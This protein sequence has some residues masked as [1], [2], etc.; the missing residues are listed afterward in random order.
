MEG[1]DLAALGGDEIKLVDRVWGSGDAG[2]YQA[3]L[4]VPKKGVAG[5]YEVLICL[6][7][8][9]ADEIDKFADA[10]KKVAYKVRHQ[11]DTDDDYAQAGEV[12]PEPQLRYRAVITC[13]QDPCSYCRAPK[14]ADVPGKALTDSKWGDITHASYKE[15]LAYGWTMNHQVYGSS[16][17]GVHVQSQTVGEWVDAS[18]EEG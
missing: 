6:S 14:R 18:P 12:E 4:L 7:H 17:H 10:L 16:T 15:A 13:S 11:Y 2:E 8:L 3:D 1:T 9:D 5:N